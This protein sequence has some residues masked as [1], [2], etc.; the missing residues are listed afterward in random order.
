MSSFD[1]ELISENAKLITTCPARASIFHR[2]IQ[3]HSSLENDQF[4][5]KPGK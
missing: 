3:N 1:P 5:A 2:C 4:D